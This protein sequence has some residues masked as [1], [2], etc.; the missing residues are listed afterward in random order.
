MGSII[1]HMNTIICTYCGRSMSQLELVSHWNKVHGQTEAAKL[2]AY[3]IRV[4]EQEK[5]GLSAWNPNEEELI[6]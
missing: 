4:G 3:A 1:L 6:G 5:A 2:L